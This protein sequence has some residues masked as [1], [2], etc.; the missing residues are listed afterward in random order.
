MVSAE[1]GPTAEGQQETKLSDTV[2]T[3]GT[4][5]TDDA[6]PAPTNGDANDTSQQRP[7]DSSQ[8]SAKKRRPDV[9]LNKD[10]HPE[11]QASGS[12][13]DDDL[14]DE[15]GKRSDPFKRASDDVLK[16]R[17]IVKASSKW[18][19][20]GGAGGTSGGGT[21]ASVKLATSETSDKDSSSGPA[22]TTTTN[23]AGAVFGSSAKLTFGSAASAGF[24]GA[25]SNAVSGGFGAGFGGVSKGF[26]A[27]SGGGGGGSSIPSSSGDKANNDSSGGGGADGASSS[28]PKSTGFGSGFGA[29]STG[30]GLFKPSNTTFSFAPKNN[31]IA[32]SGNGSGL[33]GTFATSA[34][35]STASPSKFPTSSV[36]DTAN[37]EQD[38]DCLCQVR[39]KLFRMV[40]EDETPATV[41]EKGDAPSVPSTSGRLELVKAKKVENE[42]EEGGSSPEKDKDKSS[43]EK[44]AENNDNNNATTTTTKKEEENAAPKLVQKEAGIGPVRILRRKAPIVLGGEGVGENSD[45]K[46]KPMSSRV[47]QRQE[48]SGGQTIRVILNVRLVPKTCSVARRSDKFVQ[49]NA[50]DTDGKVEGFLFKVK[51]TADADTLEKNL[52][53]MLEEESE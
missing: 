9:Q 47:V 48:T 12:E 29:T 31:G 46:E 35:K 37:G 5:D 10:E 8:P 52:K 53:E 49:L 16:K 39:A 23:G 38:E 13:G 33:A 24:G 26:G 7:S 19:S 14:N 1:E 11:G 34:H 50:P 25:A 28:A 32:S 17:K 3:P 40:P 2:A 4:D 41:E 45:A 15:G 43:P 22:T 42:E 44:G 18:G 20:G 36:V 21:F 27:L 6:A 30:F 51:S